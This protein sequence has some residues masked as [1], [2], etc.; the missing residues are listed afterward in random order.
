MI[1]A[2]FGARTYILKNEEFYESARSAYKHYS[3]IRQE[4]LRKAEV[5]LQ[6]LYGRPQNAVHQ[7]LYRG[8]FGSADWSSPHDDHN[9]RPVVIQYL[10]LVV[11]TPELP[12]YQR[13]FPRYQHCRPVHLTALEAALVSGKAE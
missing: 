3:V 11:N 5:R 1:Y 9:L 13:H 8:E 12:L 10:F 7:Q 6:R 2:V 4:Q